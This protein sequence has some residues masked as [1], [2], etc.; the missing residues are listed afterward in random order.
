MAATAEIDAFQAISPHVAA[1][2]AD[3]GID[4]DR[5]EVVPHFYEETFHRPGARSD[6]DESGPDLLYV[7]RLKDNKGPQVLVR[8]LAILR[9]RGCDATLT[10]AG[11]GS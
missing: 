4:R 11:D 6:P 9:E 10:V 2:Y 1:D 7:G 8:A 5:I 3:L